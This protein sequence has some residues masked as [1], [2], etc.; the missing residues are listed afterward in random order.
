MGDRTWY[1]RKYNRLTQ[2]QEKRIKPTKQGG[3]WYKHID[4]DTGVVQWLRKKEKK[5]KKLS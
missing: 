3:E 2:A 4:P 1:T 5:R